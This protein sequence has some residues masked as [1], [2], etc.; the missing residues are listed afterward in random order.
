MGVELGY[1]KPEEAP[2]TNRPATEPQ[3]QEAK[4]NEGESP[5]IPE[6]AA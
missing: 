2:A 3:T 6:K 1:V 4:A 5:L